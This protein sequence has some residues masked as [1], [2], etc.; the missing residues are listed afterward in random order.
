MTNRAEQPMTVE[1]IRARRAEHAREVAGLTLQQISE[2]EAAT[3]KAIAERLGLRLAI[4]KTER[5]R[6]STEG[7]LPL[8]EP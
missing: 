5:L 2:R 4:V 7:A 1:W 8:P 3:V 6:D